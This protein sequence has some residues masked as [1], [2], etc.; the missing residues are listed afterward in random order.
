MSWA[1][2]PKRVFDIDIEHCPH[3]GGAQKI[4]AV[5]EEPTMI[6]R[7]LAHLGLAPRRGGRSCSERPD[8]PGNDGL[9]RGADDPARPALARTGRTAFGFENP[10]RGVCRESKTGLRLTYVRFWS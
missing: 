2:L 7:I 8:A 9:A 5:I 10:I 3:C 6:V 4:I 1:R